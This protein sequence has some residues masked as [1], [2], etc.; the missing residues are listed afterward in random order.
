MTI[1][2]V[3]GSEDQTHSAP[4]PPCPPD[5]VCGGSGGG[6]PLSAWGSFAYFTQSPVYHAHL[7]SSAGVRGRQPPVNI[8]LSDTLPG[9]QHPD[10]LSPPSTVSGSYPPAGNYHHAL[11]GG[12]SGII[13]GGRQPLHHV[14]GNQKNQVRWS[15]NHQL[16]VFPVRSKNCVDKK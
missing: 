16:Q 13:R 9:G 7:I 4:S 8:E 11:F 1:G 14:S 10:P 12:L 15:L 2:T 3:M 5:I 6:S